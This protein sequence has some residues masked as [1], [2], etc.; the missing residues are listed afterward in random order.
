MANRKQRDVEASLRKKGFRQREGDHSFF[1]YHRASDEKKT[2]V[3]T[4]TSHGAKEVD[5]FLLGQ[6]AKQCHL[7][8]NEF[9]SLVDCTLDQSGYEARLREKGFDV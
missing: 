4:K 9:L 2:S 8:R 3:F 6:M 1:V 7:A 5:G